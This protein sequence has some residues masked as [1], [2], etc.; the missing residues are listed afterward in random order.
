MWLSEEVFVEVELGSLHRGRLKMIL[1]FIDDS[2]SNNGLD[3]E[4]ILL[5]ICQT[6]TSK[7]LS[8]F[9][10]FAVCGILIKIKYFNT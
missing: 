5:K 2:A 4:T 9:P 8:F 7:S 10:L 6:W 3:D 1:V